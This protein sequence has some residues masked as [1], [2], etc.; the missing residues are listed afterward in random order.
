MDG[1][2]LR[3]AAGGL[4]ATALGGGL[5]GELAGDGQRGLPAT[6]R[7]GEDTKMKRRIMRTHL[8]AR[9]G[10]RSAGRGDRGGGSGG[11]AVL[12]SRAAAAL[13]ASGERAREGAGGGEARASLL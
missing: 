8:G 13:C 3:L 4:R 1:D 5:A 10:G 12:R 7:D 6:N 11:R 9:K 2:R